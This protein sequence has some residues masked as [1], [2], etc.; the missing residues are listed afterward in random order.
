MRWTKRRIMESLRRT[1][2]GKIKL[3]LQFMAYIHDI[4]KATPVFQTM[5]GYGYSS[6]LDKALLEKAERG[7]FTGISTLTLN[8]IHHTQT[9]QVILLRLGVREDI[10][11]IVGGHHGKPLDEDLIN[12]DKSYLPHYYQVEDEHSLI[13]QKWKDVQKEI[14]DAALA[15]SGF[16]R[17]EDLPEITQ[18]GVVLI[19]ELVMMADWIAS[20]ERYFPLIFTEEGCTTDDKE[21]SILIIKMR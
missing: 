6:D 14:L 20:N 8:K 2:K 10:A 16:L 4:G 1:Q 17:V 13:Y 18:P 11:S 15:K 21:K 5:K 9:G 12:N 19:K 3:L 7:G